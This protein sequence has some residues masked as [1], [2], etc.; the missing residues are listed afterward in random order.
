MVWV[1]VCIIII[2]S[3]KSKVQRCPCYTKTSLGGTLFLFSMQV[4]DD[5]RSLSLSSDSLR[6]F[7]TSHHSLNAGLVVEIKESLKKRE[8]IDHTLSAVQ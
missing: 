2:K 1:P 5:Q 3:V 6:C 8:K 4:P 7:G